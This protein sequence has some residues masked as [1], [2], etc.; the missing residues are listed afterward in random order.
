MKYFILVSLIALIGINGCSEPTYPS[1]YSNQIVVQGYLMANQPID[2]IIVRR[3]ARLEEY[4]SESSLAFDGATVVISGNG[5]VDTLKA[6]PGYPGFYTSMRIPQ[7]I[8][9]PKQTY[10]LF[11][12]APDD[13]T[14]MATTTVPDTFH[15]IDK[16]A[17]PRV[18]HYR[19]GPNDDPTKLYT[20]DW[21]SSNTFS[22]YITSVTSL[23]SLADQIP[24]DFGNG[25]NNERKP[26]R[27]SYGFNYI[28]ITHAEIPWFTFNYYGKHMLAI[29]AID[30]NYYDFIRQRNGG[31]SDIR[32]IKYNVTG[33]LGVFGSAAMDSL[34][35]TLAP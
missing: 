31:G 26:E 8:I 28:D 3:T 22:D 12:R 23:D 25:D 35:V 2:S 1:E 32:E 13:R 24:R 16:E 6:M 9:K 7:N 10:T 5:I 33:G 14:V 11:V 19:K 15:I 30:K 17:F 21:T 34:I 20:M 18:L 4:V 29:L 27:T